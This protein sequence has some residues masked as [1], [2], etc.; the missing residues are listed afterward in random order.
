MNLQTYN[1][2]LSLAHAFMCV[3]KFLK[4]IKNKKNL[5]KIIHN[6]SRNMLKSMENLLFT[7]VQCSVDYNSNP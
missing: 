2:L 7:H 5:N 4:L 6:I 3:N 1:K